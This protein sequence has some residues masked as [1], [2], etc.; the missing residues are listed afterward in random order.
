MKN[1]FKLLSLAIV[2]SWIGMGI[3]HACD[4]DADA[5]AGRSCPADD[6]VDDRDPPVDDR[7]PPEDV[8]DPTAEPVEPDPEPEPE[9]LDNGRS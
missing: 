6:P 8:D 2:A 4:T 1:L 7:D 9:P 5:L 3:A